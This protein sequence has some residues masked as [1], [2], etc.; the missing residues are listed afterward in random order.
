MNKKRTALFWK[1]VTKGPGC[2]THSGS[3]GSHGYP[4]ATGPDGRS[5]PAARVALVIAGVELKP[6]MMALHD[7]DNQR[8]VRVGKGHVYA[9]THQQN[10]DDTV[11]RARHSRRH[12]TNRQ[13]AAIRASSESQRALAAKYGVTQRTIWMIKHG[14]TYYPHP[15]KRAG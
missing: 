7:C 1:R 8:C 12:F 6:G 10:M 9:G 4:Q 13:A 5:Q 3:L 2:W 11:R 15:R 14:H